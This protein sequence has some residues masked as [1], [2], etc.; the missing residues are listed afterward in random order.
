MVLASW[1]SRCL[2]VSRQQIQEGFYVSEQKGRLGKHNPLF[3]QSSWQKGSV[4][5]NVLRMDSTEKDVSSGSVG[6][7]LGGG[8][9]TFP[10]QR[11]IS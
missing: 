9:V 2:L 10:S 7:S 5:I 6:P 3:Y 1:T 4:A 8:A 11:V